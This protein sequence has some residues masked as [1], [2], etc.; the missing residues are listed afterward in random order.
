ML[1]PAL[2]HLLRKTGVYDRMRESFAYDCYRYWKDG[3]SVFWRRNELAF[4]RSLLVGRGPEPLIFDVG[5]NRGQRTKIFH[6][7]PARVVALEPDSSNLALL[8]SRFPGKL[9]PP[10]TVVGKAV[11]AT[12]GIAT[13][14][15]LEPGSG[16]NTLSSKWVA[17]LAADESRFGRRLTFQN[18]HEVETTTLDQLIQDCGRP[19]YIKVDVEGHEAS[20]LRGLTAP[21][22]FVSFEVILPEFLAEGRECVAILADLDPG[23]HFNWSRDCQGPCALPRWLPAEEFMKALAGC[24]E[25]SVEVFGRSDRG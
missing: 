3:R 22:P 8:A 12:T 14:W 23:A 19:F 1:K 6:R 13:L 7:L 9:R 21:V 16:L 20:V 11:S 15:E 10:V 4:Y 25:T 5:A 24:H 18:R 17:T 2:Q